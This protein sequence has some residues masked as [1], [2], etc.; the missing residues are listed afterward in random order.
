M[1]GQW[2][3]TTP[4]AVMSTPAAPPARNWTQG[5][6]P[7][8]YGMQSVGTSFCT[9]PTYPPLIFLTS[10]S[11]PGRSGRSR[12]GGG[13]AATS[14]TPPRSP[15]SLPVVL[16]PADTV[17]SVEPLPRGQPAAAG[18]PAVVTG[19]G[20]GGVGGGVGVVAM[21]VSSAPAVSAAAAD[22][23]PAAPGDAPPSSQAAS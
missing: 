8:G 6:C 4:R 21:D 13:E 20:N 3:L 10:I 19:G 12:R 14:Q 15:P 23:A 1:P 22:G 5:Q 18:T 17:V 7:A 16:P 11:T 9:P 2:S